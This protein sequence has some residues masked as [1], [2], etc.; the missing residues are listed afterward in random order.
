MGMGRGGI[1]VG[2]VTKG[3]SCIF[4]A[5]YHHDQIKIP[6]LLKMKTNHTQTNFIDKQPCFMCSPMKLVYLGRR[7]LLLPSTG[8]LNPNLLSGKKKVYYPVERRQINIYF[9]P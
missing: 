1:G 9:S 4:K 2:N 6:L 3:I 7:G 8:R 5:K